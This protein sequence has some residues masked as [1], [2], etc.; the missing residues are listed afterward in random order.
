MYKKGDDYKKKKKCW[1]HKKEKAHQ[2][3]WDTDTETSSTFG[4][5]SKLEDCNM[6]IMERTNNDFKKEEVIF[7]FTFNRGVRRYN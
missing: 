6:A 4:S 2:E 5:D 3:A 1:N 7:K